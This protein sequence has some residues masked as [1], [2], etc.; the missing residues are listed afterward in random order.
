M[1]AQSRQEGPAVYREKIID[2]ICYALGAGR[3]G[4]LRRLLG[5]LF[6]GPANRFGQIAARAD[7]EVKSSGITGGARRIL[8]DFSLTVS[9]RGTEWIPPDGP[10]LVVSN[11]PGGLDSVAILS[12]IRRKDLK[13]LLSDVPFTRAFSAARHY[14]IF[15]PPESTG[16]Q[17][18]LRSSIDHLRSGGSLLIFAHGDVEPDPEVSPGAAEAIRD[19]S[20]SI[21]IMLRRVPQSWLQVAI[22]SGVLAQ[23][24][25]RNPIVRIRKDPAR[26]QKLAEVLQLS[27]QMVF[28][29]SIPTHVHLSFAEPVKGVELAR[30]EVMP[31]LIGIARRLLK[32]HL[33]SWQIPSPSRGPFRVS[34]DLHFR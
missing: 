24:S 34:S 28:P 23:K 22:A 9:A 33:E 14:F 3:S 18:A 7:M 20:R 19:W 5:P 2:E 10:L 15:V 4:A 29:R 21:E 11:H 12:S 13:V 31:A 25:V 26:R 1:G 32:D 17:A 8:P 6:R 27:R 30:V 16:R